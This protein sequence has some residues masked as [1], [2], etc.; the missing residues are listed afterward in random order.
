MN[1]FRGFMRSPLALLKDVIAP[2]TLEDA[3]LRRIG[4]HELR[5]HT[6]RMP[7][8]E[9]VIA[10]LPFTLPLVESL[11]HALKF[12][13]ERTLAGP[14]GALLAEAVLERLGTDSG[15]IILIPMPL[16]RNRLDSRGYN[17]AA[18]IAHAMAGACPEV[19]RVDEFLLRRTKDTAPQTLVKGPS[20][21]A[22]NVAGAFCCTRG[23][24]GAEIPLII[25]DDVRT[26]GATESAARRALGRRR[27]VWTAVC[28]Q[29]T[30]H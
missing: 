1:S 4:I 28:A 3:A 27:N 16:S 8:P 5:R 24:P 26:T 20:A 6:A 25:V 7:L 11:I 30:V 29:A 18:L 12:R 22:A 10:P 2:P 19:F 17:Q 14:L 23:L 13:G 15:E 21:R 9:H